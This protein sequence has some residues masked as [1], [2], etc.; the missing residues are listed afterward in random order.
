MLSLTQFRKHLFSLFV[1]M[2]GT[3]SVFEVIHK[4][5]VFEVSV[6]LT[7]KKPRYTRAKKI[8]R[9]PRVLPHRID[10]DEC[11]KCGYVLIQNIC[12]NKRCD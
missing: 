6:K 5:K 10:V 12:M 11:P 7:D 8:A 9:A 4:G 3:G 1:V 2:K